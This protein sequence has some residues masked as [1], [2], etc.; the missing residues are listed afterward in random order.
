MDDVKCAISVVLITVGVEIV[1]E[2][3]CICVW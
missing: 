2:K 3:S 1:V